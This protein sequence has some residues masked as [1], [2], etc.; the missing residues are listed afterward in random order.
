MTSGAFAAAHSSLSDAF[1]RLDAAIADVSQVLGFVADPETLGSVVS[2]VVSV[3]N[4]FD[5]LMAQYAG[6]LDA[7]GAPKRAGMRSVGQIVALVRAA[8][9]SSAANSMRSPDRRSGPR[10]IAAPS[11]SP[12][13]TKTVAFS[14]RRVNVAPRRSSTSSPKAQRVP[15][16]H[17]RRR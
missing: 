4:R 9:F 3:Q 11:S 8:G 6:Q 2:D 5:A 1:G 13:S 17:I 10:L 16:V 12:L 15:M 7:S 14:G